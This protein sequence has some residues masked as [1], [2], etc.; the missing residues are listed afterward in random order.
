MNARLFFASVPVTMIPTPQPAPLRAARPIPGGAFPIGA[1]Q[2]SAGIL[3]AFETIRAFSLIELLVVV[4]IIGLL[5]ALTL[6]AIGSTLRGS[7]MARTGSVLADQFQL[8]RQYATARGRAAEV[9][10]YKTSRPG[11][12]G[13]GY[14][15]MQIHLLD[16]RGELASPA[17]PLVQFPDG[18]LLSENDL[19]SPLLTKAKISTNAPLPAF[20]STPYKAFRFR[21]DGSA[22]VVQGEDFVTA[23]FENDL[24]LAGTPANYACAKVNRI[25]GKVEVFRP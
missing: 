9:R 23:V 2:R 22:D 5:A 25:N 14:R 11:A 3:P 8:A 4:A 18:V 1:T 13:T 19:L 21:P 16:E 20:G 17:S 12:T 24:A 7:A 10:L 6:P 15:A